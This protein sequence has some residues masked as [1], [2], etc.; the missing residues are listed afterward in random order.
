S[1]ISVF[2]LFQLPLGAFRVNDLIFVYEERG[3][4]AGLARVERDGLRDEWTIVELDAVDN[5]EA[6]D[7][8][9]RLVQHLLRD[10]SKR[11]ALRFHVA[12]ADTGGNVDLFMQAGFARYG[13]ERILFRPP[14]PETSHSPTITATQAAVRGIRPAGPLDAIELDRLY[15]AATPA[16]VARLEDYRLHDWERQGVH[17][18]VPRS[19]LTPLLRFADVEAFVQQSA[20]ATSPELLAFCQIGVAKQEQPH[21]IRVITRPEHDPS[22]LIDY[23][24]GVIADRR[25]VGLVDRAVRAHPSE[26]GVISAVRTYE[27]PLDRRLS[28]QGFA[29]L[30]TVSLLMKEVA[31]RVFEPSLVAAVTN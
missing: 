16:P 14:A 10:A 2:S 22:D 1:H 18:R 7:I 26:R 6:G 23:G 5:G 30:S 13:E 11:G 25:R 27:S 19:S 24:L 28:D 3:Q 17:W 29:D 31:V 8:R 15:H 12:C 20:E 21:Y 9:F 4:I